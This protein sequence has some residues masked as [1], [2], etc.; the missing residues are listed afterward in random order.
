MPGTRRFALAG[1][2]LLVACAAVLQG[3]G[4]DADAE[5]SPATTSTSTTTSSTTTTTVEER[6]ATRAVPTPP[7]A[8]DPDLPLSDGDFADPYLS[9]TADGPVA[10]ATNTGSENVPV[11]WIEDGEL[12]YAD[13][14]PEVASWS[15][16]GHV[17]APSVVQ[18]DGRYVMYYTTRDLV[19]GF[20]CIS[21]ATSDTATGPYVDET[22]APLV[23]DLERGGSIDPSPVQDFDGN[24]YLLWKSDGNCCGQT[25]V[26]YSQ[27]LDASGTH[28]A[29]DAVALVTA[30]QE[31]EGGIVEAPSMAQVGDQW[32]LVYSGSDWNS[33]DYAVG[34]AV[35]ESP[36]GPCTKPN[37]EPL[38][39]S[40]GSRAGPGGAELV[41]S[42]GRVAIV[43]H[44]WT[45]GEVG[46]A[47]GGSRRLYV[48]PLAV[49]GLD[50][51]LA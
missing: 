31:W 4:P 10:F 51:T 40:T 50:V 9:M 41:A 20:Q 27:P 16:P 18:I 23:C 19:S 37:D 44:A 29:G 47:N 48:Q 11:G 49:D 24:W 28:V 39:A 30:D 35:C 45:N 12:V 6:P 22:P 25:T 38:L 26:I 43:Y 5:S 33:S 17:W 13:A 32:Y 42:N 7:P 34:Y 15:E 8:P 46:Y 21:V 14:L 36:T 2:A 3:L 1:A